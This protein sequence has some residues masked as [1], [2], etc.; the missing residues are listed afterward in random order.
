MKKGRLPLKAIIASCVLLFLLITS[1]PESHAFISSGDHEL[2]VLL[3]TAAS[4]SPGISAARERVN[5]AKADARSAKARLGPSLTAGLSSAWDD[6]GGDSKTRGVYDATLNLTQTLY[7]GGSVQAD[8]RAAALALLAAKAEGRR[9]YQDALNSV[10]KSYYGC[11]RALALAQVA[12]E[13]LSLSKEHLRQTES[14]HKAG[15]VPRGDVLRVRISVSQGEL[16]RISAENDLDVSWAALEKAAGVPL[17][18]TEIL[19]PLSEKDIRELGPP[20]Y[21]I[22]EDAAASA[23]SRRPEMSAYGFYRRRAD[24]LISSA[25][26]QRAPKVTLSGRL[27]AE[28]DDSLPVEEDAWRVRLELQWTLYDGGDMSSRVAKAKSA[29]RE[30]LARMDDVSAQVRQEA[31]SAELSLRSAMSRMEISEGQVSAAEDGYGMAL[32]RYNAQMGTNLDVLDA[33]AALTDSLTAYVD[34]IYDIAVA[35]AGL[36][37]AVGEDVPPEGLFD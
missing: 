12:E 20:P 5:Q 11:K 32:R 31:I 29:A 15:M 34:A 17:S 18:K 27:A 10:R 30:L 19:K 2:A 35:Q 16:D 22:P 28:V 37:Y 13:S 14:L 7:A 25:K 6:A 9:A 21:D 24:E 26:G 36:I 33:R 4:A 1:T 23:L 3:E 8:K